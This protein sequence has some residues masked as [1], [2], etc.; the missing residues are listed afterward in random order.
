ML[1]WLLYLVPSSMIVG[2]LVVYFQ[3]YPSSRRLHSSTHGFSIGKL[4]LVVEAQF[5][6]PELSWASI[7]TTFETSKGNP[8]VSIPR[9]AVHL[10]ENNSTTNAVCNS[11]FFNVL[12]SHGSSTTTGHISRNICEFQVHSPGSWNFSLLILSGTLFSRL[13]AQAF[14]TRRSPPDL[15]AK[16]PEG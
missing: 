16:V 8:E 10:D 7:G 13:A 6:S 14:P 15:T 1:Y 5:L 12:N 9:N 2:F 4:Q 3:C 11:D